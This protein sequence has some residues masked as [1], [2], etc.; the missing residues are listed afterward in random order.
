MIHTSSLRFRLGLTVGIMTA[1]AAL[2]AVALV[3]VL[4]WQT[5]TDRLDDAVSLAAFQLAETGAVAVPDTVDVDTDAETFALLLGDPPDVLAQ[6]GDVPADLVDVLVE[7]IWEFTVDTESAVSAELVDFDVVAAGSLCLDDRVCDTAIVGA[8]QES[9]GS[10]LADRL[11]WLLGAPIAAGL[12]A[13]A[14]TRWLVTRSLAPVDRMRVE[15]DDITA[16][17]LDRRVPVPDTDDELA[18]LGHS[19]NAT[20]GRLGDAV[21]AN[22]RFVADAAHELRSPITGARAAI[23]VEALQHPD[24]LLTDGIDELD[25]AGRLIDDLLVLARRQGRPRQRVAVDLDDLARTEIDR[26]R[27]R[28]PDPEISGRLDPAQAMGNA[29]DV[30]RAIGNLIENACRYGDGT[31][32]VSTTRAAGMAH[33]VVDDDG[34][35]IDPDQRDVVFDRFARLDESRARDTG[36]A[37][38]GLAIVRELVSDLDGEVSIGESE[39]GGASIRIRLP[40]TGDP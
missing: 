32:Q 28:F 37:G 40:A 13:W 3:G 21:A 31:V 30:R 24:R 10:Y 26:A 29:D 7:E 34:P 33:V 18:A 23:E 38:L 9:L 2:V 19:M 36:G 22:E 20:I 5:Q 14:L 12:L 4:Q 6:R 15:L 39:L 17:D 8:Y 35:G 25:R 1:A 11:L 27:Q 16:S